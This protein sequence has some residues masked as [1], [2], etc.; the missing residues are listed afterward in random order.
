LFNNYLT[1]NA[2]ALCR[3]PGEAG[4]ER[5]NDKI[6]GAATKKSV[7]TLSD[8]CHASARRLAQYIAAAMQA[9]PRAIGTYVLSMAHA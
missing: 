2:K 3:F 5:Q 7:V 1:I 4:Y 6:V 8:T 9:K